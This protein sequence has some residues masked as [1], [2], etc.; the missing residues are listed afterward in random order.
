MSHL[1][2]KPQTSYVVAAGAAS[3]SQASPISFGIDTVRLVS[4]TN[5]WVKLG[6]SPVT[7]DKTT[8]AYLPANVVQ[9]FAVN[10]NGKES[11]AVLQDSAGGSLV[12][13]E[14]SR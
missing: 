8:S 2:M 11:F 14:M 5:C 6:I 12:I 9:Y 10:Q 13:T 3:A 1:T 7:A 4:T